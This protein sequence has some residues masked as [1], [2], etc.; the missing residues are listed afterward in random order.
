MLD[1]LG[2]GYTIYSLAREV[3][4]SLKWSEETKLVDNDWLEASGFRGYLTG[5]G[6]K[7]RW[8]RP[9]RVEYY[10]TQGYEEALEVDERVRVKRRLVDASGNLLMAKPKTS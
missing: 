4:D 6:F 8:A 1:Y 7:L 9:A 5:E 2:L 10:K 3:I